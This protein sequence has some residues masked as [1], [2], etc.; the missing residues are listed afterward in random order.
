[1]VLTIGKIVSGPAAARY[2]LDQI[3]RDREDYYAGEGEA[4]GR[5]VG[6]G[7]PSLK[8]S[9]EVDGDDFTALLA[10][11][12]LRRPRANGVA[13]FDLTFRAPKSV[14]VLCARQSA[15]RSV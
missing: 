14:S 12:G 2:Y 11:A 1:V 7:A 9:G 13:G 4:P 15:F 3:A 10:G 6:A 5:W 8:W